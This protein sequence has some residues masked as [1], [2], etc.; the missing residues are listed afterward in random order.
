MPLDNFE[1]REMQEILDIRIR[2]PILNELRN[3]QPD[4]FGE[5]DDRLPEK[6]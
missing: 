2:E 6:L 1:A 5:L 3:L 4:L